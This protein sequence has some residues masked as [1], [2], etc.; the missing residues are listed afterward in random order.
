MPRCSG[1]DGAGTAC[2]SCR[3]ELPSR[4]MAFF[5]TSKLI[6]SGVADWLRALTVL[7]TA[8]MFMAIT[9]AGYCGASIPALQAMALVAP[10]KAEKVLIDAV[11]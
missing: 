5:N 8:G 2:S 7:L 10:R 9:V 11:S 3:A 6:A 1:L 4:A